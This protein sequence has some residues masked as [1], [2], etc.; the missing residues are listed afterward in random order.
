MDRVT[1]QLDGSKA[2][3]PTLQSD[4][5]VSLVKPKWRSGTRRLSCFHLCCTEVILNPVFLCSSSHG[6]HS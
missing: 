6:H 2:P 5:D 4:T 3:L 1:S